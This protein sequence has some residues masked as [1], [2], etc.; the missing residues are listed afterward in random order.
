[1]SLATLIKKGGLR[2]VAT[3]TPATS[4]TAQEHTG[5]SV[6][7]VATVAVATAPD[8][9]ANDPAHA[10]DFG[11]EAFEE[12]AA[13]IEIDGGMSRKDAEALAGGDSAPDPDR[14]CWPHTK[15]MNT[16]EIDAFSSRLHHFTRHGLD[17]T[18]AEQLADSLV[19]RDRTNDDRRLCLECAHLKHGAGLW[20]C[21]QWRRAGLGAACVPGDLVTVLQRCDGFKETTQ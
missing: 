2:R 12:R 13:I 11:R 8:K 19:Q 17:F 16:A 1:M 20:G 6:A 5:P 4:A 10:Q 14:H 18:Q 15:T 3:A 21:N 7:T 9:A